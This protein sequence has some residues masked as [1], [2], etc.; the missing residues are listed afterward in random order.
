MQTQFTHIVIDKHN[1]KYTPHKNT[2][3]YPHGNIQ[4]NMAKQMHTPH[5]HMHGNMQE[6]TRTHQV[7]TQ[8]YAVKVN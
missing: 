8:V 5:I 3:M 2:Q 7:H 1:N 6:Y 4:M